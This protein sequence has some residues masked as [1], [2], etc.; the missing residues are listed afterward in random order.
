[1]KN[2]LPSGAKTIDQTISRFVAAV[3]TRIFGVSAGGGEP[4]SAASAQAAFVKR[5][6][7]KTIL[8]RKEFN[9][10]LSCSVKIFLEN[11][12]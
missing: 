9:F 10:I 8:I 4:L 7:E 2:I 5:K 1:V 6:I 3:S 11:S 12:E